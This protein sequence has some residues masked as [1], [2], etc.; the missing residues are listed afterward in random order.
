VLDEE[1]RLG[2]HPILE[3][4]ASID[5]FEAGSL[6]AVGTAE[7]IAWGGGAPLVAVAAPGSG[8]VVAIGDS[9]LFDERWLVDNQRFALNVFRWI[10]F[11]D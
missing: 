11:M 8:R 6:E 10:S 5:Y 2:E 7:V 4:V 3:G 9:N 1:T